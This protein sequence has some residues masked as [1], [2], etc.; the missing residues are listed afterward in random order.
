MN[1]IILQALLKSQGLHVEPSDTSWIELQADDTF[2]ALVN[3]N[4]GH[5]TVL[6]RR[7]CDFQWAHTN[8][9]L[10]DAVFHGRRESLDTVGV[11]Q[12]LRGIQERYGGV[13]L[14]RVTR[15]VASE[16]HHF[17]EAAG[18]R[19]ML[20]PEV[21]VNPDVDAGS[22]AILQEE[23]GDVAEGAVV[24]AREVR[25]VTVNVDG[26]G[27]YALTPAERMSKILDAAL[28]V[29]PEVLLLQE[30]VVSMYQVVKRRLADWQIHRRREQAEEYFIVTAVQ[31]PAAHADK[32]SSF[33]FPTSRNGRHLLTVRRGPWAIVNV[34][35]E[36]G[37]HSLDRDERAAQLL[38]LSR[39][40][41]SDGRRVH[42]LAGDFNVRPEEDHC[43]LSEGWSDAWR[44]SGHA[45][46]VEEWTWQAGENAARYDRIYMHGSSDAL[47]HCLHLERMAPVWGQLTDHVALH[48]VLRRTARTSIHEPLGASPAAKLGGISCSAEIA[49]SDVCG[50]APPADR[51][52]RCQGTKPLRMDVAVVAIASSVAA[53]VARFHKVAMQCGDL[54]SCLYFDCVSVIPQPGLPVGVLTF[55]KWIRMGLL[56]G[57]GS[58]VNP[59]RLPPKHLPHGSQAV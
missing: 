16:G 2:A 21:D 55:W 52:C 23:M 9:I 36:S 34:H 4:N 3:C 30:V 33:A 49:T 43:L 47:V 18:M 41:E 37:G 8:S 48:A 11:L 25:L 51:P 29:S 45:A 53:G 10:G 50:A 1:G 17:L 31:I 5:W 40:H 57:A 14:H 58:P 54:A 38:H 32:C 22:R 42:V 7:S 28:A 12:I 20:P 39:L 24:P 56:R 13:T 44:Q 59:R 15:R 26:L 6:Y 35:A 46:A 27:D 19:A